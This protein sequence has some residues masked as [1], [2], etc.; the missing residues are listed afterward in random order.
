LDVFRQMVRHIAGAMEGNA[1][2]GRSPGRFLS[3][4]FPLF[5]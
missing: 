2:I 3:H 1:W 4:E 5:F